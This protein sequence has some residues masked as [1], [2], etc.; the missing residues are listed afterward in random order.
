MHA[1]KS[2]HVSLHC[3]VSACRDISYMQ[4]LVSAISSANTFACCRTLQQQ[5]TSTSTQACHISCDKTA[6]QFVQDSLFNSQKRSSGQ[7]LAQ[8]QACVLLKTSFSLP[9]QLSF[10]ESA[11]ECTAAYAAASDSTR[12]S[13]QSVNSACTG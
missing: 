6:L 12:S 2:A 1:S 3:C 13:F 10:D 5:C 4:V 8:A 7:Q 9:P 11:Y